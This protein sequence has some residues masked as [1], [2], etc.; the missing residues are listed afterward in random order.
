MQEKS[1]QKKYSAFLKILLTQYL[2]FGIVQ[3]SRGLSEAGLS[4]WPVTPE[5]TGS[6]PVAPVSSPLR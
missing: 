6:S 1:L 5:I 3:T 2:L 4:R